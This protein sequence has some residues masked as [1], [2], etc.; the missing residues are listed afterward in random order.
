MKTKNRVL[1]PLDD[2]EFS[3]SVLPH[4]T[5]LLAPEHNELILLHVAPEPQPTRIEQPQPAM[6]RDELTVYLDQA[7]E[8]VRE[9]YRDTVHPLVQSLEKLGYQVTPEVSFGE[10]AT[11]IERFVHERDI[12]LIAMATHGRE[13]LARLLHG[14]IA[15]H[16]LHHLYVPVLL[17]REEQEEWLEGAIGE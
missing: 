3:L 12:D 16:I 7:E 4:V 2:S 14:S 13:G 17:L 8:G 5:N 15:H 6:V 1:I 11:Q 9:N 10:P